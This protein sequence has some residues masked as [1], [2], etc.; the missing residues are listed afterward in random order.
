MIPPLITVEYAKDQLRI[1]DAYSDAQ[2]AVKILEASQ[3]VANHI[4]ATEIPEEWLSD[5]I[6]TQ[7]GI[8][9]E[10]V[11]YVYDEDLSPP[12][13]QYVLVPG[14]VQA[15]IVLVMAELFENRESGT[16]NPLSTGVLLLLE[17]Y[18]DPTLA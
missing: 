13:N 6:P 4:K 5:D 17:G 3:I 18:R 8:D 11:P 1:L 9:A 2:I 14:N 15:A 10:Y 7:Y 12:E 16:S